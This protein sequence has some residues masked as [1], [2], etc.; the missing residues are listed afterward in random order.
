MPEYAFSK[1]NDPIYALRCLGQG[2][3]FLAQP[4]LRKFILIPLLINVI[5]FASALLVTAYFFADF[6]DWL[7]P[8]WLVWL[9]WVLWPLFGLMFILMASFGFTLVANLLASPFYDRLA[10]RTEEL[11]GRIPVVP[12]EAGRTQTVVQEIGAE[13]QRLGYF[14]LRAF[15]LAILTLIP[16]VNLIA[17]LLGL[18]FNA[19]FLALEYFAY[20][21]A[22]HGI[23]FPQARGLLKH[24][25]LGQLTFGTV[26]LLGLGIPI[27]NVFLPPAAVIGATIYFAGA[28]LR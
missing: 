11:I 6:L 12:S 18:M 7:I 21:L 15:P 24:A 22:N 28:R 1:L 14:L 25:W 27:V 20:P 2:L 3:V 19:W 13:I 23:L 4:Q 26:V 9:R 8:A 17:P 10:E 5:L 16:G